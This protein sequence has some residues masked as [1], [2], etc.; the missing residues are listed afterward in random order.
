MAGNV[1]KRI[2]IPGELLTEKRKMLGDHVFQKDGKIFADCVG[3]AV[4]DD[5]RVKVIPL[6]GKYMPRVGDIV[7][8]IV[9]REEYA[10]YLVDI[11]AFYHAFILKENILERNSKPQYRQ[12][13]RQPRIRQPMQ[14]LDKGTI[15]SAKIGEV[16]EINQV[17]LENIRIY[18]GG[19]ILAI[20]PVKTPRVIG[21]NNSMLEVLKRG[22]GCSI[23]VGRNGYIWV[24]G[25][26]VALLKE[27]LQ[28][29][30]R[31]AH[32][33]NLTQK[34]ERFL[35]EQAKKFA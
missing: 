27:A 25:G 11:N 3:L 4:E 22:T 19:E 23:L 35:S 5:T 12:R 6:K 13:A 29:I 10:G 8:G 26:N 1:V 24:K 2:V 20:S 17:K 18:H 16:D 31:E 33:E 28:L 34:V 21:K 30:E 15:I 14:H 32:L 7:V 9:A